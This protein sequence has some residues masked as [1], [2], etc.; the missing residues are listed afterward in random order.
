M[1]C[2]TSVSIRSWTFVCWEIFDYCFSFNADNWSIHIFL[3]LPGSVLGECTFLEIY[4]FFLHWPFYWYVIVVITYDPLCFCDIVT[5]PFSL[6]IL[7]E[8]SLSILMIKVCPFL[9]IFSKNQFL[10]SLIFSDFKLVS[11]LF[12]FALIFYFVFLSTSWVFWFFF[13]LLPL[14]IRLNCLRF[15]FFFCS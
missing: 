8:F 2:S 5:F 11:I 3:F 10:V 7:F 9:F 1:V 4:A 15:F 12:I 6:N 13:F 14:G